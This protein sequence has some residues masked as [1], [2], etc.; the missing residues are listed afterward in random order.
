MSHTRQ[1]SL[2]LPGVE[3]E[4]LPVDVLLVG[5]TLMIFEIIDPASR[6]PK[7]FP[8]TSRITGL[9][10]P[11]DQTQGMQAAAPIPLPG[12]TPGQ[13]PTP[14]QSVFDAPIGPAVPPTREVPGAGA[15]PRAPAGPPA[16]TPRRG[17]G[18]VRPSPRPPGLG[19]AIPC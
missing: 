19:D 16:P 14:A 5:A 15:T 9:T 10:K 12:Q 7:S 1:Y 2:D 18:C 11:L 6:Q 17:V 3:R 13:P 4:E 8:A